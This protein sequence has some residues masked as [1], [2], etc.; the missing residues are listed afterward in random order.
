[1]DGDDPPAATPAHP[2]GGDEATAS[3]STS[4][5]HSGSMKPLTWTKVQAGRTAPKASWWARAA[6]FQ[7]A[8][9]VSRTL[10]RTTSARLAP[11]LSSAASP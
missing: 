2:G 7:R 4:T 3:S 10:V 6:S 9:P 1:M 11:A 8:M 5:S